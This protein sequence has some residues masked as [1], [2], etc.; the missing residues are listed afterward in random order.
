MY[1]YGTTLEMTSSCNFGVVVVLLLLRRLFFHLVRPIFSVFSVTE[2]INN[3][4]KEGE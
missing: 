2:N 4:K 1:M 3:E